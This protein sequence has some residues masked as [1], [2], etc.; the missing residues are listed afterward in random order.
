MEL[1]TPQIYT[2]KGFAKENI[3]QGKKALDIG[4]GSRKLPGAVGV[5]IVKT[6]DVDILHDL[7]VFPWPF[8]E[9]EFDVVFANHFLEHT[10]DLLKTISEIHRITRPGAHIIIQV[11]YFRSVDA[12]TDPTHRHFFTSQSL[13]YFIDGT[14]CAEYRYVPIRFKKLAFWYGWPHRS[15][16]PLRELIKKLAYRAPRFYD[17]YLSLL[18]PVPCLTFELEVI[19]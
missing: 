18:L 3:L 4:C 5:D 19:K 16:N 1:L 10:D 17:Q 11:P 12:Y 6:A 8:R 15:K 7:S 13:D 2:P 14:G 9:S